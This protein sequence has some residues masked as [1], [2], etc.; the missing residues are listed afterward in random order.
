MMMPMTPEMSPRFAGG[1]AEMAITMVIEYNAEPPIP[2]SALK[3]INCIMFRLNAHPSEKA[4]NSTKA[5]TS[6]ASFPKISLSLVTMIAK[7]M[8]VRR[9]AVMTHCA[10]WKSSN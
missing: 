7:A 4:M 6:T 3:M 10:F 5:D 9:Y 8:Y 2:C 1:T